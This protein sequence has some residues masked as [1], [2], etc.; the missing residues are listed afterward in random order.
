MSGDWGPSQ[1][2]ALISATKNKKNKKKSHGVSQPQPY[3]LIFA[4]VKCCVNNIDWHLHCRSHGTAV[5]THTLRESRPSRC[6]FIVMSFGGALGPENSSLSSTPY[7]NVKHLSPTTISV[8][9]S[10]PHK[11]G[12]LRPKGF[13]FFFPYTTRYWRLMQRV[14]HWSWGSLNLHERWDRRRW[15]IKKAC[16]RRAAFSHMYHR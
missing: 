7:F 11:V 5:C 15:F 1:T 14:P 4:R 13:F 12:T 3:H 8:F 6:V 10:V 9:L 16:C 2:S